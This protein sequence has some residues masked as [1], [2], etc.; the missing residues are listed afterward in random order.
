M[1]NEIETIFNST[2]FPCEFSDFLKCVK[3]IIGKI[4]EEMRVFEQSDFC[5]FPVFIQE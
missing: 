3:W 2:D 1:I 5:L 4:Y